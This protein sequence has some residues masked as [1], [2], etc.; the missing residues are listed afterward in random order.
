MGTVGMGWKWNFSYFCFHIV[1]AF[2]PKFC[3]ITDF[4]S[5]NINVMKDE[6]AGKL[7]QLKGDKRTLFL[8]DKSA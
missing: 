7:F 1:L 6:H 5:K 8:K 2:W 3:K 4:D